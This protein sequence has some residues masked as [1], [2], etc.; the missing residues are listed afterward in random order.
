MTH[1]RL[2]LV[3]TGFLCAVVLPSV[4]SGISR[5]V[6]GFTLTEIGTHVYD[7]S[8]DPRYPTEAQ[9][10]VDRLFDLG[11]RHVILSPRAVMR[12]P[13]GSTV[14]FHTTPQNQPIERL[15]YLRLI[16]HLHEK[17][18]TVGMRPIVMVVDANGHS[19]S[20]EILPNGTS[21]VWWHGIIQ[22]QNP[23]LWFQS[24]EIY[25]AH[26]ADI[27]REAGIEEFTL[28]AELQSMTVGLGEAWPQYPDGF[29]DRFTSLT[30]RL[31][32]FLGNGCRL[33]YDINDANA[34]VLLGGHVYNGGEM[35]VWNYYVNVLAN[36]VDPLQIQRRKALVNFL[37]T[38]DGVGFDVYQSLAGPTEILPTDYPALV[39]R[40][41]SRSDQMLRQIEVFSAGI[42]TQVGS[43][44]IFLIKEVG[45]KSVERGFV[46][47]FEFAGAGNLNL[48]HQAAAY[49]A[50]FR[51]ITARQTPHLSGL[52]LWDASVDLVR[53]GPLDLGFSPLGKRHSEALLFAFFRDY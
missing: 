51:S 45:Y 43:P 50:L 5:H 11:V 21:K 9:I 19:P 22:P 18:M 42:E 1:T 38:L 52:S 32:R 17:G 3:V 28:G 2:L 39:E 7:A 14:E 6:K 16:R 36:S 10:V 41:Q 48:E 33:M 34:N 35:A 15:R 40:L 37:R 53:Q 4:A 20:V 29:A 46:S 31:R 24:F 23:E 47:P 13:R 26:Y 12:N 30:E 25:L 8:L 44:K 49:D 27:A